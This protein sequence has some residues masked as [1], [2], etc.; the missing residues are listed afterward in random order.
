M[1]RIRCVMHMAVLLL[2]TLL[3]FA[4]AVFAYWKELTNDGFGSFSSSTC[5]DDESK[6]AMT[7]EQTTVLVTGAKMSK[8]LHLARC[9]K[10]A[11]PENVRIILVEIGKY[12]L[13]GSRFSNVVDAFETVSNPR[14]HPEQYQRDLFAL[15]IKHDV[16][17]F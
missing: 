17:V 9:L 2:L 10:R 16:D 14:T 15:C 11:D 4:Y 8:S 1:D 5:E 13:S 6:S 3:S 12:W 7:K